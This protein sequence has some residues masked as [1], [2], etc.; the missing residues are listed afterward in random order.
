MKLD[1]IK[2]AL[3]EEDLEDIK[4]QIKMRKTIDLLVENAKLA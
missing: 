4:N 3:R 2:K 1:E